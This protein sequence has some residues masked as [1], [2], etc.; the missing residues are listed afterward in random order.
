MH[1]P[2]RN[3]RAP[4]GPVVPL[5]PLRGEALQARV[6]PQEAEATSLPGQEVVADVAGRPGAVAR[7]RAHGA[8]R[9]ALVSRRVSPAG[10]GGEVAAPRRHAPKALPLIVVSECPA[11]PIDGV[12]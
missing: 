7:R 3:P 10:V 9:S 4:V 1:V 12:P 8:R 6:L 5:V 11:Y 2:R